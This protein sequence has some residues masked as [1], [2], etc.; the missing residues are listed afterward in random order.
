MFDK[1][2][3]IKKLNEKGAILPC[4]RCGNKSFV[5]MDGYSKFYLQDIEKIGGINL[6]DPLVPV[7][8]VICSNCGAIT[9]HAAGTLG[10]I[11]KEGD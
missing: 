9:F 3:I 6:G 1:D 2:E 4:S 11:N 10:L 8:G 7:I 5:L